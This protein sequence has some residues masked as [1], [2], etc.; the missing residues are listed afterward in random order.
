MTSNIVTTT[1]RLPEWLDEQL[2]SESRY[3]AISKNAYILEILRRQLA[4]DKKE[5]TK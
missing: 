5:R 4:R 3:N 2:K 1:L